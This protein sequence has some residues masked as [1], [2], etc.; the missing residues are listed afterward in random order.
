M[1]ESRATVSLLTA[2]VF[3]AAMGVFRLT[4]TF[5]VPLVVAI[6][7]SFILNPLVQWMN[8]HSVPT[9][10][11]LLA[12]FV[13]LVIFGL[14]IGLVLYSSILSLIRQWPNYQERF[15]Q[16]LADAALF[17]QLPE[18]VLTQLNA[19][20]RISQ[21]VVSISGNFVGFLGRFVLVVIFLMFI[22]AERRFFRE[23]LLAAF[24]TARNDRLSELFAD[25][26][27]QVARYLSVKFLMSFPTAVSVGILFS[28][29]GVDFAFIW[30]VLTFLFNWIPSLGSI[31]IGV[32]STVFVVIQFAPQWNLVLYGAAAMIVPQLLIGN[33]LD[34]KAIGD[35]LNLSPVVV[36][37]SLLLWGWLWGIAGLFLAVPLTVAMKILFE[38]VPG[39]EFIAT[40]MGGRT[41]KTVATP[42]NDGAV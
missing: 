38:N 31:T 2:L 17:L 19:L 5:M 25:I 16:L 14:L 39:L 3:I 32:L 29:I 36:I 37:F 4:A 21:S 26:N 23:R 35:S 33:G 18:D 41:G 6:L 12:V 40:L 10:L 11:T 34:P 27:R 20:E 8:R 24:P 22:L 1:P 30:A 7:L 15:T 13:V 42:G 28:V 9:V